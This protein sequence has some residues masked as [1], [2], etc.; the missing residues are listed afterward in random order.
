M[1]EIPCDYS[2]YNSGVCGTSWG[3]TYEK[4]KVFIYGEQGGPLPR[5][6]DCPKCKGTGK[7]LVEE[8]FVQ[9]EIDDLLETR[10][11]LNKEL[12]KWK[13]YLSK[14]SKPTIMK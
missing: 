14:Q 1:V 3:G 8:S 2:E 11:E 6:I 5:V 13:S 12:K 10:K 9:K 7:I 4:G